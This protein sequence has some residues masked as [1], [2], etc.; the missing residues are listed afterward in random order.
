MSSWAAR[1]LGGGP[2]LS[3]R[4]FGRRLALALGGM[5][6][7]LRA[8]VGSRVIVLVAGTGG[9]LT[10]AKH[11]PAGMSDAALRQLGSVGYVLSGAADRFDSSYYLDIAAHGYG[12]VASGKIAFFPLY[13]LLIRAFTPL[14]GSAAFAGVMISMASFLGALVVLHRLT[15]LELG[16]PAA[17][18]TVLLVSFAPL[19]FF[20]N[21]VYTE[22]LFLLLSVAATLAARQ[23]RWPWACGLAALASLTRPTGFLLVILLIVIHLR[24]GRRFDRRSVGLLAVP[25]TLLAY[26]GVLVL[27]GYSWLEPFRAQAEWSRATVGP[28]LGLGAAVWQGLRGGVQIAQGAGFY[29]PGLGG[30]F[31]PGAEN[32]ILLVKLIVACVALQWC[33]R[34]LAPQY[35]AYALGVLVVCVSSPVAGEPLLSVDRFVLTTFPLWMAA[36]GWVASRRLQ[37][38]VVVLSTILLIFYTAQAS[39]WAFVA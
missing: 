2:A 16:R 33:R 37:T 34:R 39:S 9:V 5:S 36:G 27:A 23:E 1:Y 12:T 10:L 21:A 7:P 32:L 13:P 22:S 29:H 17:D 38:P 3:P 11:A 20:F 6:L 26:I 14:I 4:A 30:P 19:S 31:T 24:A 35:F 15:E 25:A 8:F 28:I 18:A